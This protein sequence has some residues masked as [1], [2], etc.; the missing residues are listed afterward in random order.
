MERRLAAVL[1]ADIV[2]F[3]GLVEKNEVGT[4]DA[5]RNWRLT[6]LEPLASQHRGRIFKHLGDGVL[7]EFNSAVNA[8]N[9]AIAMHR[10]HERRQRE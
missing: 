3:S 1:A 5:V 7:I 9:F 10:G 6:L 8:V 2:G 4:I